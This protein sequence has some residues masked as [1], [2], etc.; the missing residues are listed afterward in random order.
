[1]EHNEFRFCANSTDVV[2][3]RGI[4]YLGGPHGCAVNVLVGDVSIFGL[5]PRGNPGLLH[6]NLRLRPRGIPRFA[7]F[8]IDI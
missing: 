1:M 3:T 4:G 7:K 5:S 2:S 6:L 8:R